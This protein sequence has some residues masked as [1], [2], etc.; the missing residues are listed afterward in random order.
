MWTLDMSRTAAPTKMGLLNKIVVL[1]M[2]M[3]ARFEFIIL[4]SL[5]FGLEI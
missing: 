3:S 2:L 5:K 1:F 4:N